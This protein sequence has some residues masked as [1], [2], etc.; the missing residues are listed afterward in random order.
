[1]SGRCSGQQPLTESDVYEQV[2]NPYDGSA[3]TS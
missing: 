3:H 2:V 1:M